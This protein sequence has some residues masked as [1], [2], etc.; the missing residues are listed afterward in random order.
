[1]ITYEQYEPP[2]EVGV[3]ACR[4]PHELPG[5]LSDI[6]LLWHNNSWSYLGSDQKYRGKVLGWVGPL[7]RTLY[8]PTY[9]KLKSKH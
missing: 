6:F 3:Y 2:E 8:D 5:L 9:K 1:M 4:V 7:Q